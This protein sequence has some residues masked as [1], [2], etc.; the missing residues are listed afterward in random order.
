MKIYKLSKR[1]L[2]LIYVL[3]GAILLLIK[4]ALNLVLELIDRFVPD[5]RGFADYYV[6]L[7]VWVIAALF[8]V[9]VL[10]FYFHKAQY[11]VSSKEITAKGG[12]VITSKQFM[13]T[14]AVKSVTSILLPLGRLTGMNFIVLNALGSRLVIP[15]LSRRDAEEIAELVN[16]SIRSRGGK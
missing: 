9:L 5:Y 2:V 12:L 14:S 10:P 16:N 15:F 4:F 8:A 1:P 11:T 7:P 13:L 6:L 3:L